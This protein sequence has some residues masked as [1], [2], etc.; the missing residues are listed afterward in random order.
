MPSKIA[1][2]LKIAL[3]F[4][5]AGCSA[6]RDSH[7]TMSRD[8]A[9]ESASTPDATSI[10]DAALPALEVDDG[11]PSLCDGSSD[12]RLAVSQKPGGG[13][14]VEYW[15][16]AQPHGSYFALDGRCHFYVQ[17]SRAVSSVLEGMLTPEQA[18]ALAVDLSLPQLAARTSTRATCFDGWVDLVAS[19]DASLACSCSDCGADTAATA[20]MIAADAWLGRLSAVGTPLTG[21]V[22][23]FAVPE[24]SPSLHGACANPQ[25]VL[26][27]PLDR[28][29]TQIPDLVVQPHESSPTGAVF[30]DA[31]D[32][33]RL[34][35][36]RA[37]SAA[38]FIFPDVPAERIYVRDGVT[39]YA[40]FIRDEPPEAAEMS[41]TN[42]LS[43]AWRSVPVGPNGLPP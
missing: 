38:M 30:T 26:S 2:T 3:A 39:V 8:A 28:S 9:C 22:R 29:V 33:A 12:L 17:P 32:A 24:T 21:P 14:A 13:L 40:L 18:H 19:A 11:L 31:E 20:T 27:W 43:S 37:A 41:I 16:L 15:S 23:A 4:A 34:R 6:A 1:M 10:V 7:P 25:T 35:Q 5:P 42:F 36:L